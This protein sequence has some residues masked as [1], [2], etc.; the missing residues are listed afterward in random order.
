M[1]GRTKNKFCSQS[2][3]LS[4][5][6]FI[7]IQTNS[8][9]MI[10]KIVYFS[11]FSLL[12][13]CGSNEEKQSIIETEEKIESSPSSIEYNIPSPAEQLKLFS[14]LNLEKN[15][16]LLNSAENAVNYST[17]ESKALNFGVYASDISY[18]SSYKDN[19]RYLDY[20]NKMERMGNDIG[21][22]QV[23]SKELT[24]QVQKWEENPDSLF[25]VSNEVYDK[26]FSKLVEINKGKELSLM[27]IGGWVE[28]MYLI[29][30]SKGTYEKN[31]KVN[32]MLADQK[33]VV[34]NLID[35]LIDYQDDETVHAY[36]DEIYSVLDIFNSMDCSS[37]ETKVNKQ[38]GKITLEGGQLCKLTEKNFTDLKSKI[39]QLRTKIVK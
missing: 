6:L 24:N 27:L 29:V 20:F 12:I 35:F 22:S 2:I 31:A 3:Q 28:S 8:A 14:K 36:I 16:K 34:E 38:K 15:V 5:K 17:P 26:T 19:S 33:L 25:V 30:N 7:F 9:L 11:F 23:F 13:S 32:S 39:N 4:Q 10:K 1:F 18:L 21:V 37:S